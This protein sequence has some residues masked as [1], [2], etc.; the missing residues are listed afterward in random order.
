MF[1]GKVVV[2][3]FPTPSEQFLRRQVDLCG[4]KLPSTYV[5]YDFGR[6]PCTNKP[7]TYEY[8]TTCMFCCGRLYGV[9][10]LRAARENKKR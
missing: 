9:K 4:V 1:Y 6:L 10:T 7:Q 8:K 3:V 5:E 2:Y